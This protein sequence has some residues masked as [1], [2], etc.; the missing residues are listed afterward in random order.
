MISLPSTIS[1]NNS[2]SGS[3]SQNGT[4]N[5]SSSSIFCNSLTLSFSYLD[6]Y[7]FYLLADPPA[8]TDHDSFIFQDGVYIGFE[9]TSRS[10]G[11]YLYPGSSFN[12]SVCG[13]LH[14]SGDVD[15]CFIVGEDNYNQW[16]KTHDRALAE[17]CD[18]VV[19]LSCYGV[20]YNTS[21][22]YSV[23][24]TDTYYYVFYKTVA[25]W[26]TLH[27]HFD[28]YRTK[29]AV[30]PDNVLESC[31]TKSSTDSLTG[32]FECTLSLP[33]QHNPALGLISLNTDAN[34]K[35]NIN[36][37][38]TKDFSLTCNARII[39]YV[40]ISVVIGSLTLLLMLCV[41]LVACCFHG[42]KRTYI[43]LRSTGEG[44]PT[45]GQYNTSL[46]YSPLYG[47]TRSRSACN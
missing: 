1:S 46:L 29:L 44:P 45:N 2:V 28:L 47:S 10:Y 16:L 41:C 26:G 9:W 34:Y 20:K 37:R 23:Q 21:Y 33:L 27:P 22:N 35:P 8:L 31:S 4:Q 5:F 13:D 15:F 38:Y 39:I 3:L 40:L 17:Y 6:I 7:T 42:S 25:V 14:N 18:S 12:M 11:F 43:R 32:D 19:L 24:Y 36:W 30:D